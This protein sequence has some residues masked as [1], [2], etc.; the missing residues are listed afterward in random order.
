[1]KT[2]RMTS[3]SR[4]PTSSTLCWYAFGTANLLMMMKKMNRL[5]MLRL[6]SV[7]YPAK[8]SPALPGPS[9]AQSS[10]PNRAARMT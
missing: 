4:M 3:A 5:S 8:N 6:Y 1:M 10:T 2:P 7:M 9:V